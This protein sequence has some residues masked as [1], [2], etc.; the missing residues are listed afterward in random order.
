MVEKS[1]NMFQEGVRFI[2]EWDIWW[3]QQKTS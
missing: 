3:G 2:E 1:E